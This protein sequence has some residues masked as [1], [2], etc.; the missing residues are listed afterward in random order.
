MHGEAVYIGLDVGAHKTSVVSSQGARAVFGS[1]VGWSKHCGGPTAVGQT[2]VFGTQA[3]AQG[4]ALE[5]VKPFARDLVVS[6]TPSIPGQRFGRPGHV[7][8]AARLLIEYGVAQ[9]HTTALL[10]IFG[11]VSVPAYATQEFKLEMLEA[12]SGTFTTTLVVPAPLA[13][14][15]SLQHFDRTL[16]VDIGEDI[17]SLYAMPEACLQEEQPVSLPLGG[18]TVEERFV[19]H[20]RDAHS[21]AEIDHAIARDLKERYGYQGDHQRRVVVTLNSKM[22]QHE[23]DLTDQL[24]HACLSFAEAL[25]EGVLEWGAT[26]GDISQRHILLAGGGSRLRG[27]DALVEGVLAVRCPMTVSRVQDGVFA[28]ATGALQLAMDAPQ[29]CW[30]ALQQLDRVC[31]AA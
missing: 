15:Y 8:E 1:A 4:D 21:D 6:N 22:G 14:A 31:F 17:T 9:V 24:N 25:V 7:R 12:C 30:D 16:V 11:T 26:M 29:E 13:V 20:V 18:R 27:I 5:L 10:P 2:A 23:H 3:I 19:Q 28:A